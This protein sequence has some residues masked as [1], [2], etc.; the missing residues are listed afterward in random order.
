MLYVALA[1]ALTWALCMPLHFHFHQ[2]KRK[3]WSLL[4]KALPTVFAATFAGAAVFAFPLCDAYARLIFISLCVCVA[5]D[6]LLDIRFEIGGALFFCGHV[7]YLL[8]FSLYRPLSWWCL[9]AFVLAAGM[10]QYFISHYQKEVPSKL[11]LAGLRIY[12]VALAAMLAF[13]IP[14]PFLAF[15]TRAV[16]ASL[17]AILFVTS[18]LTLCH[19]TLRHKPTSWHYVSLGIYYTGQLLL[20]LSAYNIP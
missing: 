11:I 4:F 2:Q 15:S 7:L 19:N 20:G 3:G 17:G 14:L 8:A 13:G 16:L 1:V 6:V 10:M 5:A 18:D 9:T 12:A